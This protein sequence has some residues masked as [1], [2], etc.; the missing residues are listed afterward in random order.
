MSEL[1]NAKANI[2]EMEEGKAKASQLLQYANDQVRDVTAML[3]G[4]AE[5]MNSH[6]AAWRDLPLEGI[7]EW[8]IEG[9]KLEHVYSAIK[10][11]MREASQT[12][13]E[14]TREVSQWENGRVGAVNE[15]R[16]I[17]KYPD[18]IRRDAVR[19]FVMM[20]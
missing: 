8:A 7:E 15:L 12:R 19:L 17:E 1:D 6:N 3:N 20:K 10:R 14:L 9:A 11:K 2:K 5:R 4:I 16:L 18:P 13:D